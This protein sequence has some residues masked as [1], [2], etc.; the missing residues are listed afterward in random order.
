[1]EV[2]HP[3]YEFIPN[4]PR[5]TQ[6]PPNFVPYGSVFELAYAFDAPADVTGVVL[7]NAGGVS[8]ATTHHYSV[9]PNN[10]VVVFNHQE[11]V[12]RGGKGLQLLPCSIGNLSVVVALTSSYNGCTVPVFTTSLFS[13]WLH[14]TCVCGHHMQSKAAR[15]SCLSHE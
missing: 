12:T 13:Q 1:M 8:A 4:R 6:S 15:Q 14:S 3:P 10:N 7:V 5:F 9:V 11:F 2:Y